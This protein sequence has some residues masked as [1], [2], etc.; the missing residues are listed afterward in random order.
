MHILPHRQ[1]LSDTFKELIKG[2]LNASIFSSNAASGK[3]G[4][5]KIGRPSPL[6]LSTQRHPLRGTPVPIAFNVR[7]GRPST[8]PRFSE[9]KELPP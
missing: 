8:L 9:A 6:L 5:S 1:A 4:R 7:I 2:I 3:L